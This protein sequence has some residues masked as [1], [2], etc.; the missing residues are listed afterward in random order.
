[1]KKTICLSAIMLAAIS[2]FFY[3]SNVLASIPDQVPWDYYMSIPGSSEISSYFGTERAPYITCEPVFYGMNTYDEFS[4]DF[5]ADHLPDGTYLC[6]NNFDFDNSGLLSRY[7]SVRRDYNGVAGYAGFQKGL[8]GTTNIILTVWDSYCYDAYGNMNIIQA[9]Q[10]YPANNA[11]LEVCTGD[12]INGEGCFIHTLLP[13]DWREGRDYRAVMQ[14]TNPPDGSNSHL[15]FYVCDLQ[16]GVWTF[17]VEYDL[18]YHQAHMNRCVAFLEDFS[19]GKAACPRSM[20]LS[21]YRVHPTGSAD[22]L[23]TTQAVLSCYYSND[24]SYQYG[25]SGN[26]FWA[27]T[28]GIGGRCT[29]P[30][31]NLTCYVDSCETGS[32]Y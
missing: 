25:S 14:L 7:S 18:G 31:D 10:V 32:P 1:M 16:T 20:V 13:Y 12:T 26:A 29:L 3:S 5:R 9:T 19:T 8:N 11:G 24:G 27:I 2:C 21:N 17:L 6:V 15:L 30:Q 4:V 22:W 28:T 23:G